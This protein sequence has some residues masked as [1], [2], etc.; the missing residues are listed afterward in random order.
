MG[1]TTEFTGRVTVEP[2][3]NPDEIAYLTKFART[4]RMH[5]NNG[6]YFVDGSGAYGQGRDADIIEFNSE[7]P[8]Q[9]G[10]WCRWV[11]TEDGAGIEWDGGEKFYD[12][13]RWMAYLIDT[14]LKS[15]ATVQ[16]ELAV[17]VDGRV[18]H[19]AFERFTFDHVV[20]GR[21]EAQGERDDD[22]WT[23][24]VVDNEVSVEKYPTMA[25]RME[26]DPDLAVAVERLRQARVTV[27][28][29][30]ALTGQEY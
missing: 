22:H 23:L 1:C 28:Q 20:N 29:F 27:S 19:D 9:P 25:E 12:A 18:Y 11:P 14:F 5:R 3:L 7:P 26:S 17:P 24:V 13:D 2:P 30:A 10:L 8:E 15:G 16:G 4:R 21:I 6:P